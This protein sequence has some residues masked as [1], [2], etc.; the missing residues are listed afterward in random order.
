MAS[1]S[2][3]RNLLDPSGAWSQRLSSSEHFPSPF[4]DMASLAMPESISNALEWCEYI[5]MSNGTYRQ[6]MER[7][8]AYFLTDIEIGGEAANAG[9]GDDEKEKWETVLDK[10]L[11]IK[12]FV[13][14][15]DRDRICYGNAFAS[16][17]VPFRRYL[18]CPKCQA[19]FPL[20]YVHEN[21]E[22]RLTT[23][24]FDFVAQCVNCRF[25]GS[26]DVKD[27]PDARPGQ[28]YLKRWSPHEIQILHDPFT[29]QT[30]YLW[31]I[32]EDYK[33]MIREGRIFHL[34][35]ASLEVIRAIKNNQLFRFADGVIY[36]M[37]EPTIAGVQN[38]GWG[39]SRLIT[40]FRQVWYVQLLHRYN[41]AIALDYVIPFRL[42]TP[43]AR[44]G[45]GTVGAM[46]PLLS[47]NMGDFM[48]QV[49]RMIG[50][51]RRNPAEWHTLPFPVDYQALGGD[52]NALAPKEL[53]DQA[54]DTLLNAS[55]TPVEL[56][57]GTLQLQTAPVSLRLFE[58]TWHHLVHDNNDLLRWVVERVSEIMS[59]ERV[60]AR[61][62]RVTHA[63]DMQRHMALLQLMMGGVIS[64]T[65]GLRAMGVDLKDELRLL[66][67]EARQQQQV[68]SDMQQEMDTTAF[69]Q[70]IAQG[71]PPGGQPGMPM[72]PAQGGMPP[73]AGGAGGAGGGMPIDPNTGMPASPGPISAMMQSNL[74]PQTP[75]E[76]M[77]KAEALAQELLGLPESQKDSELRQLKQKHPVLHALVTAALDR[78]RGRYASQGKSM[79]MAQDF[80]G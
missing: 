71:M 69:G 38:R 70:Q 56:Y 67:E 80:G 65:T 63:D 4:L 8:I 76:M 17:G 42:L 64:Q 36:H 62:K 66:G 43:A 78:I 1:T 48:G 16:V 12:S 31:K 28:L 60:T 14:A 21:K 41:E 9:L 47:T 6:A 73:A 55:G 29:D 45:G 74:T 23:T 24:N 5:F 32:P 50:R 18:V 19:R 35:R 49:R 2:S 40:N 59:W 7:I 75:E 46:D 52:A 13:Q 57:R 26:F 22:F 54:H 27:E 20:R 30:Q 58:A 77:S 68:Q 11:Q 79:L 15:M 34:E 44:S 3:Y 61:H 51:R 25:R 37:R 39:I 10:D 72:N 53:L 33:K